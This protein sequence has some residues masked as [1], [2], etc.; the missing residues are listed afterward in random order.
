V[1]TVALND[2]VAGHVA[3]VDIAQTRLAA[4]LAG[5]AQGFDRC[6]R[7]I[8]HAVGGVI[9]AQVLWDGRV[10]LDQELGDH[11]QLLVAVVETGDDQRG[12][13]TTLARLRLRPTSRDRSRHYRNR[14]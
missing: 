2:D 8:V 9:P 12:D 6:R 14:Y 4:D 11:G 1:E 5:L 10:E 7:M 13:L 3:L